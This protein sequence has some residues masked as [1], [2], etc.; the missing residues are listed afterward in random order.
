MLGICVSNRL[1]S[2]LA[3]SAS[4]KGM[5]RKASTADSQESPSS[6]YIQSPTGSVNPVL[7]RFSTSGD[8]NPP[9]ACRRAPLGMRP[10]ARWTR[11]GVSHADAFRFQFRAQPPVVVDLAV[12]DEAVA[13]DRVDHRLMTCERQ[14]ANR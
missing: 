14:V 3:A 13:D 2:R 5:W 10:S 1:Q 8:K 6:S 9:T 11:E 7:G 4:K 12:Q